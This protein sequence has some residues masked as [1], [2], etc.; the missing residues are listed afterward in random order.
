MSSKRSIVKATIN[1]EE[2]YRV[3]ENGEVVASFRT[4]SD[5]ERY[6]E[7]F[8]TVT[9]KYRFYSAHR[10]QDLQ[11]KCYN[12]HGHLYRM[13]VT[14]KFPVPEGS[15]TMLFKDIDKLIDPIIKTYDHK[16]IVDINDPLFQDIKGALLHHEVEIL[17]VPFVTSVENLCQHFY[18]TFEALG[19]P[20]QK[21]AIQET[22]SS[23][24]TYEQ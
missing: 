14:L 22:E 5:A 6:A 8:I 18:K 21:I 20:I 11:D 23:I 12:L 24:V 17:I 10:N 16:W 19:L 4:R 3:Y 7:S 15:V 13:E 9:R 2:V 1:N